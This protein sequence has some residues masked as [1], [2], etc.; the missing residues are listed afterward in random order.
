MREIIWK[1]RVKMLSLS[2]SGD[3]EHPSLEYIDDPYFPKLPQTATPSLDELHYDDRA[4]L[5]DDDENDSMEWSPEAEQY[6]RS[7]PL[8]QIFTI[9]DDYNTN[10][11]LLSTNSSDLLGDDDLQ[12]VEAELL[13]NSLNNNSRDGDN[14]SANRNNNGEK[15]S[16]KF[17][18][19]IRN[20]FVKKSMGM[21]D[22]RVTFIDFS[23]PYLAKISSSDNYKQFLNI[24]NSPGNPSVHKCDYT[25]LYFIHRFFFVW[26]I[27]RF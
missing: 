6:L 18:E 2:T 15:Q 3:E 14:N 10:T 19:F 11:S 7:M 17:N 16:R 5:F 26:S 20:L 9:S 21:R 1:K 22:V 8:D 13:G 12:K 24:G 23:K 25:T 27:I 4:L